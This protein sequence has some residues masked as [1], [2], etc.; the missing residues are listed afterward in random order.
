[1]TQEMTFSTILAKL[2]SKEMHVEKERQLLIIKKSTGHFMMIDHMGYAQVIVRG[3]LI[4][5]A[6][7][8]II[9]DMEKWL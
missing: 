8:A 2:I 9:D 3:N 7:Y 4:V 6:K 5:Q 1:M